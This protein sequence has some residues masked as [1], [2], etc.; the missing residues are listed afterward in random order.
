[1]KNKNL[2][3]GILGAF[4]ME[5]GDSQNLNSD[6]ERTP[7]LKETGEEHRFQKRG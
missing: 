5:G 6:R 7:A 4:Q 1:M 2:R 3:S